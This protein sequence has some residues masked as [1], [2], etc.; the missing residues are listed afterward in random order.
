MAI[1][2]PV[3]AVAHRGRLLDGKLWLEE[4]VQA[5]KT[6]DSFEPGPSMLCFQRH[7]IETTYSTSLRHIKVVHCDKAAILRLFGAKCE[8]MV[9]GK[10]QFR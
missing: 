7:V 10:R 3:A 8:E 4:L 2:G 1:S 6:P 5:K 9:N